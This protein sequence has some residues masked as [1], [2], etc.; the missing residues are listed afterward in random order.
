[1]RAWKGD[2]HVK[3]LSSE[4]NYSIGHGS[5]IY[6]STDVRKATNVGK[7]VTLGVVS[8]FVVYGAF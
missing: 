2:R 1:M 7:D 3:T 4:V 6:T 8:D 5:M